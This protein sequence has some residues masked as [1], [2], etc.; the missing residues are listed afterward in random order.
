[1]LRWLTILL[2]MGLGLMGCKQS[3][4]QPEDIDLNTK[5]LG[6]DP[7]AERPTIYFPRDSHTEDTSLNKFIEDSLSTAQIGDYD[8]FR[9]LF[10]SS[11]TPPEKPNFER[12]WH[13][14]KSIEVVSVHAD[15][16]EPPTYYVHIAVTLKQ[17]DAKQRTRLDAVVAVFREEGA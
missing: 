14:V 9:Q 2:V 6:T 12:I 13:G 11:A 3:D 15:R 8:R 1:M 5:P 4:D 16:E 17:P 7:A 10:A